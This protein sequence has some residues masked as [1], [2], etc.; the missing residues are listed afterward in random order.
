MNHPTCLFVR[1]LNDLARGRLEVS[2]GDGQEQLATLRLVP[3]AAEQAVAHRNQLIL[4]HG[5][6]HT[7]EE[8]IVAVQGVVDAVLIAQQG[9]EDTADVDEAMPFGIRPAL[10]HEWLRRPSGLWYTGAIGQTCSSTQRPV[11]TMP[12]RQAAPKPAY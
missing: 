12:A 4:T 11:P 8:A 9:V 1:L 3:T 5:T 10:L 7:K 2:Q 6:F